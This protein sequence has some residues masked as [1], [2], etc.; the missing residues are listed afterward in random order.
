MVH[1]TK[2]LDETKTKEQL[3]RE[4]SQAK[5]RIAEMARETAELKSRNMEAKDII[6]LSGYARDTTERKW[7]EEAISTSEARY[8]A[9]VEAFDGLIYI[10]SQDYRIEF[11]NKQLIERTGYDGTGQPCYKVLHDV[12]S[13]CPWCI[14]KRVFAG[15]TIRWE[16]QSPKDNRWYYVV[17]T[18][19]HHTDGSISKQAMVMDITDRKR[20]EEAFRASEAEMRALFAAMTD[21]V[22][23]CNS[24]GRFL[25]IVAT[26]PSLLYKPPH[27]LL[28]K[29]L[30]DI[31]PKERADFFLNR[32]KRALRSQQPVNFEYSLFVDD[33]DLWFNATV[34]PVSDEK[35]LMVARDITNRKRAEEALRQSEQRFRAAVDNFPYIYVLYGPDLRI[36]FV[37]RA[38]LKRMGR[39]LEQLVGRR[40]DELFPPSVTDTYLSHLHSCLKTRRRLTFEST[41]TLSTGTTTIIVDYVPLMDGQGQVRQILG[42]ATDITERK[43]GEE[44]LRESEEKLKM[45][46]DAAHMVAWELNPATLKLT[47][48][49]G[50][51]KVLEIPR[52]YEYQGYNLIHPD[53][54][55]HHREL[56]NRAIATGDGYKSQYRLA[57]GEKVI[58]LEEHGRAVLDSAG[59]TIRLVGVVHNITD[60]KR[61]EEALRD[62]EKRFR[63]LADSMPQLVWTAEPEGHV[64]YYNVRY[65]QF[66][67]IERLVNG[68]YK[69]SPFLHPEDKASTVEAWKRAYRRG[70]TFQIEHRLQ[71][72]DGRYCWHLSR[73]IP[74]RDDAG[75]IVKW[76]GTATE[77]ENVKKAELQLRQLNET[78]EQK[79]AERTELAEARSRQLQALAIE[80]IESE[81]RERK[82]FSYLLH[83]DLQQMLAAAKMQIESVAEKTQDEQLLS[84][85]AKLLE[86][87]IKKSRRL[88]QEL[89]PAIL[90]Q[91]GLPTALKWLTKQMKER[92]GLEVEFSA[93]MH[94][95]VD[96]DPVN[97]FLYRAARELLFNIV[98]HAGVKKAHL[99]VSTSNG[100]ITLIVTDQGRGFDPQLLASNPTKKG[101][102]LLSIRERASYIG[103]SLSLESE[104]GKG[105]RFT[106]VVPFQRPSTSPGTTLAPP[107]KTYHAG[108]LLRSAPVGAGITRVMFVDDHQVMRQGL[109]RL[110]SGQPNI[111]V[112]G[113]ASN[114]LEALKLARQLRPNVIVM[115][116][117]M[118]EMDGIEAT[119]RIKAEMPDIHVI[120]LSM[121]DDEQVSREIRNAGADAFV[122][123]TVPAAELI[124]VIYNVA[125]DKLDIT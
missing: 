43:K 113:E 71:F 81:E 42:I 15:E 67:G 96:N 109:I 18:P 47:L 7:V 106:L 6:G 19:I 98:K 50:A 105:S 83:D 72:K 30:H 85:A 65:K 62:S 97:V 100:V 35:I 53:D 16:V 38:G 49:K 22:F 1:E 39:S 101:F 52:T 69:W 8:K 124:K 12:D 73:A 84:S 115:D 37:N 41:H 112:I 29:T 103:G 88:S 107:A 114:G 61:A 46:L 95:T 4:L 64:D 21:V 27:E 121:H 24:E 2:L 79:V 23:V 51:E 54:A 34:S 76:F 122:C 14:N 28:G 90:H 116:V 58:W 3:I 91:S 44:A 99:T 111:N 26:N 25:K 5:E 108:L 118:P 87:S 31:F 59:K 119:R 9:I 10:C 45:A 125:G 13:I 93:G 60:R 110:V 104:T 17:N 56:V 78:L 55:E 102:G 66:Q 63:E 74:V 120:G 33:K 48:S 20:M 86:E 123:K 82:E 75:R 57:H 70:E 80:L 36:Q 117:S 89:S 40:D 77:I 32:L 92:F 68:T 94:D 11:M